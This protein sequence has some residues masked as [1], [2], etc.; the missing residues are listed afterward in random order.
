MSTPRPGSLTSRLQQATATV[1]VVEDEPDIAT[2]LGAFFRASGL[3][4][5]HID[6]MTPGEVV[7]AVREH[8]PACMLLDLR[9]Q[10]FT[11][12]D[13]L[14]QLR[15]EASMR[16]LPVVVFSGDA[17]PERQAEADVFGVAAYVAK[18]FSVKE[19]YALVSDLVAHP[20][21]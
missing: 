16:A 9:L 19:L 11:G 21:V 14:V 10:G 18:P 1:L 17:R 5:V 3:E 12:L 7:V 2:F 8:R 6:P 4:V 20:A 13:V 15:A